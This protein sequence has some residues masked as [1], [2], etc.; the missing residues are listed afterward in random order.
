MGIRPADGFKKAG[1][2]P[3]FFYWGGVRSTFSPAKFQLYVETVGVPPPP[4]RYHQGDFYCTYCTTI[5]S[6][7]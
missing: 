1:I 6:L 3:G 2:H 7:L 5:G 4:F